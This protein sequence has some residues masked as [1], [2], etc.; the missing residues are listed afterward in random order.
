MKIFDHIGIPSD[1]VREKERFV[2]RTGLASLR[3]L[4]AQ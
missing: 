3:H 1:C 4:T 2:E